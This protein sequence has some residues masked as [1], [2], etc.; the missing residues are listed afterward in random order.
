LNQTRPADQILVVNDGSTDGTAEI[1]SSFGNKIQV[2][3]IPIA[4]GNKSYAQEYGLKYVTGDVF[5]ATDADTI[6]DKRFIEK[7]EPHFEDEKI[8]AVAGYVKSIKNNWI[9]ACREIDYTIGQDVH[10]K[11]QSNIGFLF[12]I[13]GCAGAFR[14]NKFK[15][16][17]S[18]EHDTLTEDLDF[19]YKFHSKYCKIIMEK[20]A[21]V[22]TQD[23]FT[24]K[25]YI[26]QIRRWY[27]G[28]WQNLKKHLSSIV[29]RPMIT[30]ELSLI[31]FEGLI[32]S[33]LLFVLPFINWWF[34]LIYI[35]SNFLFVLTIG[36]Y[37]SIRRRRLDLLLY[38]PLYMILIFVNAVVFIEQFFT[39]I[40]LGKKLDTWFKPERIKQNVIE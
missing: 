21:I 25:S 7:I 36:I 19:T 12:V 32:F 34:F 26:N 24:L 29:S 13:P 20:D 9:T 14:T 8:T 3:T 1:L 33:V 38:S 6:I 40:I 2:I 37:A 10:K 35:A 28:G 5:I 11:A 22:Y 30:L 15:E 18:F 27:S 16:L 4:T 31:Y 39:E 23:P 17:I